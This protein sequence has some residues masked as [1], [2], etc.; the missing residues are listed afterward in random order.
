MHQQ[1]QQCGAHD[2]AGWPCTDPFEDAVDDRIEHA[3]IRHDAEEEDGE[4][5]HPDYGRNVLMPVMMKP[6]VCR[7]KP[8]RRAAMM[9]RAIKATREICVCS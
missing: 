5:K 7:P 9:G 4:H 3:G 6:L 2:Y 1:R 8:A